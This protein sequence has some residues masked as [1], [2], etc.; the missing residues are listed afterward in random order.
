VL[1]SQEEKR[2]A[3]RAGGGGIWLFLYVMSDSHRTGCLKVPDT[4]VAEIERG[5]ALVKVANLRN[6]VCLNTNRSI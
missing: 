2:P 6:D 1:A 5:I 4:I 3:G